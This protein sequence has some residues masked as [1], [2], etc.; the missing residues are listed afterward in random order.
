MYIN[1]TLGVLGAGN[2]GEAVIRGALKASLMR[3]TQ[4]IASRRSPESLVRLHTELRVRTT[5]DNRALIQASDV[6][7]ICV[8]PQVLLGVLAEVADA[9]TPD[10]TVISIA[11][12]IPVAAIEQVLNQPVPVVRVMP[13]TPSLIGEAASA[14]CL[15]R[16]ADAAHALEAAELFSALGIALQVGEEH[17][18]AVTA[19]S[20][21][22]PAYIF[23]LLEALYRGAEEVGLPTELA[24]AL[25][26]QTVLGAARLVSDT[27][28][29]PGELRRLVTSPGGTTE[30]AISVL[31]GRGFVDAM[32][33]AIRAA[34]DRG[35]E[36]GRL[37]DRE[38]GP[39]DGAGS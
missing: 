21:S 25:V 8:K 12:G 9:F 23:Y 36:L 37:R 13:N 32:V 28:Q 16:Y 31:A 34:R 26:K 2:M 4:I 14:Y 30:A 39:G 5:T 22:G 1:K 7:V 19:V 15:G 18:D 6:V 10:H 27:G 20:G 24:Q 29:D 17:M 35:V 38:G 3:P 33:D 11:A